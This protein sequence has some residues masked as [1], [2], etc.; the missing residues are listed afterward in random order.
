MITSA[1]LIQIEPIEGE[2]LF[3]IDSPA[4]FANALVKEY[5]DN[6]VYKRRNF[7]FL[8]LEDSKQFNKCVDLSNKIKNVLKRPSAF[9]RSDLMYGL[10][11]FLNKD[12]CLV[13]IDVEDEL[14][15]TILNKI[16][17]RVTYGGKVVCKTVGYQRYL[18]YL[19]DNDIIGPSIKHEGLVSWIKRR[20]NHLNTPVGKEVSNNF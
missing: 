4:D 12:Y 3:I 1:E 10:D 11:W 19:N 13:Y 7:N 15:E 18:N 5:I 8:V 17:N 6:P 2:I 14:T 20:V 9:L 16:H